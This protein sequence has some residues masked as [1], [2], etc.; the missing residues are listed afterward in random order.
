MEE[1]R[2]EYESQLEGVRE[3]LTHVDQMTENYRCV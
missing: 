3:R 1:V 2:R